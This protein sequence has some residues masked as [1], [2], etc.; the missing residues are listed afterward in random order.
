[1]F[2][3]YLSFIKVTDGKADI[4]YLALNNEIEQCGRFKSLSE[5]GS[6]G[7]SVMIGL[8]EVASKL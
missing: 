8:K 6:D 4:L 5:F 3:C 7:A 1:M 2:I